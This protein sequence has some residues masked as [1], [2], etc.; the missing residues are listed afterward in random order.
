MIEIRNALLTDTPAL[1]KL[2]LQAGY[3]DTTDFLRTR[4]VQLLLQPQ[5]EVLVAT[6]PDGVLLGLLH[7]EVTSELTLPANECVI[8]LVA[9]A[10]AAP[11]PQT[12]VDALTAAGEAF[13]RSKGCVRLTSIPRA[14]TR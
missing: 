6:D 4:L 14:V 2:L 10:D 3:P 13:A 1:I 5:T 7:V 8:R 12:T 11:F 9:I